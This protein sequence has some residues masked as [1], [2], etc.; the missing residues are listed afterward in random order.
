MG[1]M[2]SS[3][4]SD[5]RVRDALGAATGESTEAAALRIVEACL[6]LRRERTEA[7]SCSLVVGSDLHAALRELSDLVR[8]AGRCSEGDTWVNIVRGAS[9]CI[10]QWNEDRENTRKKMLS[11]EGIL[12]IER[13][14]AGNVKETLAGVTR[15]RDE[16][17]CERDDALRKIATIHAN[18]NRLL[19]TS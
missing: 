3:S 1:I 17:R 7:L 18:I 4:S 10:R 19:A 2:S 13:K 15:E 6:R 5:Y 12:D 9:N 11:L 8:A 14:A 16:L